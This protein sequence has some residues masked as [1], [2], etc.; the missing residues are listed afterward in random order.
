MQ[1]KPRMNTD[2]TQR[3]EAAAVAQISK[4]AVSQVS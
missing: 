2:Q 4:S 3:R 1:F